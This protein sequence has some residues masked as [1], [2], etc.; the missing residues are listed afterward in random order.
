MDAQAP[1]HV[2]LDDDDDHWI[3]LMSS[4]YLNVMKLLFNISR[5]SFHRNIDKTRLGFQHVY[6]VQS[7]TFSNMNNTTG[8]NMSLY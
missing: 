5:L 4:W 1:M 6:T 8:T 2:S 3:T 7:I